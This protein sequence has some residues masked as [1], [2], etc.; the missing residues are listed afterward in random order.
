MP[1]PDV[2][3]IYDV[4]AVDRSNAVVR[5][6]ILSLVSPILHLLSAVKLLESRVKLASNHALPS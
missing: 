2:K 3:K 1:V 4:S 5:A 6:L